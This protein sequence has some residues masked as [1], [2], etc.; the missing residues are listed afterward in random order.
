MLVALWSP[1]GGAGTSV[2]AAATA[3]V[4]AR[5]QPIRL[6]D[7]DGD[8]PSILGFATEP[9]PGLAEWL[10]AGPGAPAAALDALAAAVASAPN[11]TLVPRGATDPVA[12]ATVAPEAG[13]ALG[14]VLRD[15]PV[16]T[17]ADAGRAEVP[18][19]RAFVEV[20]DISVVVVR[21]CYLALR[22]ALRSDLSGAAGVVAMDDEYRALRP[23]DI[24]DVLR[25]PV[26]ASVP[27][28]PPVSRSVDAG[29]LPGRMP[30][31]LQRA[32][33]RFVDRLGLGEHRERG[34]STT[35]NGTKPGQSW[36]HR[37]RGLGAA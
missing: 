26:L 18:A 35:G 29:V 8:Q 25:L 28:C 4:L 7:L 1:S 13:A 23:R 32:A 10:A 22:R 6:A 27:V 16:L 15:S 14:V 17:I 3:L 37:S 21:D 36:R 34:G 33:R 12:L 30:A 9:S 11:L 31:G 19:L 2:F 20:A 5:R 24:A